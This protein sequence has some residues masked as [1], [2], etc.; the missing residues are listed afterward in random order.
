VAGKVRAATA[1]AEVEEIA[2]EAVETEVVVAV[3]PFG[4]HRYEEAEFSFEIL[5]FF[6]LRSVTLPSVPRTTMYA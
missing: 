5:I 1:E 2:A 4:A 3:D 6:L